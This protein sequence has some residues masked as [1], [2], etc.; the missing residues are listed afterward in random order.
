MNSGFHST[1]LAPATATTATTTNNAV[2]PT[3]ADN[4]RGAR[5]TSMSGAETTGGRAEMPAGPGDPSGCAAT[6]GVGELPD[7]DRRRFLLPGAFLP[8]AGA[9]CA[10]GA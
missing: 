8:A 5:N 6:S 7:R 3:V 10:V 2:R 4:P 1:C 9:A